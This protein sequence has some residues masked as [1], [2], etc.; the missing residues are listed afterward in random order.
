MLEISPAG[1]TAYAQAFLYSP[2]E[3]GVALVVES[4]GACEVEVADVPALERPP[5]PGRDEVE[6]D[7]YLRAGWNRVMVKLAAG[8]GPGRFRLRAA[9]PTGEL[10]WARS[11]S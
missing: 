4:E 11:P 6:L 8:G 9:D 1:G 2:R 3:R 10:Y 7:A 5:A